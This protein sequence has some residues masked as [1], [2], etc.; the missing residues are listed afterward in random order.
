M[1]CTAPRDPSRPPHLLCLQ[2]S[3]RV[4]RSDL[5][6][7]PHPPRFKAPGP[8]LCCPGSPRHLPWLPHPHPHP[9]FAHLPVQGAQTSHRG[10][11]RGG[12]GCRSTR[13]WEAAVPPRPENKAGVEGHLALSDP[14][15]NP[16]GAPGPPLLSILPTNACP[17]RPVDRTEAW[18]SHQPV[19]ASGSAICSRMV[20][21]SDFPSVKWVNGK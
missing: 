7:E 8:G 20:G 6:A 19:R 11:Q 13:P 15:A 14:F 5:R 12:L 21:A 4:S 16:G 3:E 9:D 18:E 1:Y 17:R 2:G 10:P